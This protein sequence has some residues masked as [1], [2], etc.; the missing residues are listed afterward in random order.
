MKKR[1]RLQ[2]I[3]DLLKVIR[4]HHNSIK[5]TPLLRYSNLSTQRFNEYIEEL[6]EKGFVKIVVDKKKKKYYTLTDDGFK[7]L[8]KYQLIQEFI[9]DFNL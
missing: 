9:A 5:P 7:Y 6:L 1:E 2:V 4:D 8:E 3:Y